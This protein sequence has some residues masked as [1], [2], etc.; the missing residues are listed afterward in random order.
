MLYAQD[1][2]KSK[3]AWMKWHKKEPGSES[4]VDLTTHPEWNDETKYQR[5]PDTI[6]IN[7]MT[8]PDTRIN[9]TAL[10]VGD[11]YFVES[12]AER[13]FFEEVIFDGSLWDDRVISRGIAHSTSIGAANTC[14][15]RFNL[16]AG[17]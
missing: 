3:K 13:E 7:G 4:W 9:Q 15:A 6:N 12:P 8:L 5:K 17:S 1:S 11:K 16:K 14:R 2:N 10:L